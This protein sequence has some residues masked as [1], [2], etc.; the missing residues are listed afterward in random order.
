MWKRA[1]NKISYGARRGVIRSVYG[2][3][4]VM[5]TARLWSRVFVGGWLDRS[6]IGQR[7]RGA[8]STRQLADMIVL[9]RGCGIAR[10]GAADEWSSS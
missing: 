6:E 2:L 7:G 8:E 5:Q 1:I 4:D 3:P 10:V 9:A